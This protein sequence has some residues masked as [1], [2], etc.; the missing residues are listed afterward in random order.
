MRVRG[1]SLEVADR[2]FNFSRG[3][4]CGG[5][6]TVWTCAG[7]YLV[8]NV[9][10]SHGQESR[11]S[12]GNFQSREGIVRFVIFDPFGRFLGRC[13]RHEHFRRPPGEV[14]GLGRFHRNVHPRCSVV[15]PAGRHRARLFLDGDLSEKKKEIKCNAIVCQGGGNTHTTNDGL[16]IKLCVVILHRREGPRR[17]HRESGHM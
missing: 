8:E 4:W 17:W 1:I 11:E 5:L 10:H 2:I 12:G 14:D 15:F 6:S 13:Q 16:K 9:K 7:F 3:E